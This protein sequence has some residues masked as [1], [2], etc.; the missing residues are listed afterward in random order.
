[1]AW[2]MSRRDVLPRP[3]RRPRALRQRSG[4]R[5]ALLL[6]AGEVRDGA[7]GEA[8]EIAGLEGPR[9]HRVVLVGGPHPRPLVWRA[10]HRDHLADREPERD[11]H[12]LRDDRDALRQRPS[13]ERREVVTEQRDATSNT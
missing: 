4:D 9:K 8:G 3:K 5:D 1:M 6:A 13:I 11:V 2:R 7:L 10:P 12:G